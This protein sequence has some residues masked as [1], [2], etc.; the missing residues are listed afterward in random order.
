MLDGRAEERGTPEHTRG[1]QLLHLW[2]L[3]RVASWSRTARLS[4]QGSGGRIRRLSAAIPIGSGGL[5]ERVRVFR[6]S[7]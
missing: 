6:G 7:L 2:M 3:K 4:R 5:G 1:D